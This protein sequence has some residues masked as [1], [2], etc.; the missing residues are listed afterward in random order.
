MARL[1]QVM[2]DPVLLAGD[3]HTYDKAMIQQWLSSH[4]TSPVTGA[5]LEHKML[6]QNHLLRSEIREWQGR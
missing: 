5:I 4:E 3:G 2:D 6:I 1:L